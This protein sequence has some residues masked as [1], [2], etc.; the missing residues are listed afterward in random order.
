MNLNLTNLEVECV[1]QALINQQ[2]KEATIAIDLKIKRNPE[3]SLYRRAEKKIKTQREEQFPGY[4]YT[5][6]S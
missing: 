2:M 4:H 5:P 3:T 6:K 1:L